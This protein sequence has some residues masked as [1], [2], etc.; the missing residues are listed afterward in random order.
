MFDVHG[1]Y[2]KAFEKGEIHYNNNLVLIEDEKGEKEEYSKN[3]GKFNKNAEFRRW[4]KVYTPQIDSFDYKHS[5]KNHHSLQFDRFDTDDL[6]SILQG[7][8][9]AQERDWMWLLDIGRQNII[10]RQ[11]IF[12]I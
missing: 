2:G 10:I 7:L 8:T 12:K 6:S 1:E 9:D 3:S 5:G 4:N 11:G